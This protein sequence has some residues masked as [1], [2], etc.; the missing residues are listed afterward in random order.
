ME[1]PAVPL[2]IG[3]DRMGKGGFY[4]GGEYVYFRQTPPHGNV[5]NLPGIQATG[6]S[7]SKLPRGILD[8]DGSI[9]ANMN[10]YPVIPIDGKLRPRSCSGTGYSRHIL[11]VWRA[12][13]EL[14]PNRKGF[15]VER[16]CEWIAFERR[17]WCR[18]W[19][20]LARIVSKRSLSGLWRTR[21]Q[22]RNSIGNPREWAGPVVPFRSRVRPLITAAGG[23]KA[24]LEM[25]KADLIPRFDTRAPEE[26]W[27]LSAVQRLGNKGFQ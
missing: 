1:D 22:I 4:V 26:P 11:W 3:H 7:K 15:S 9:T 20:E 13:L 2:P 16:L 5:T 25:T 19:P 10:G 27:L 24:I 17:I 14:K 12:G 8:Y 6:Q 18:N 21:A 23:E